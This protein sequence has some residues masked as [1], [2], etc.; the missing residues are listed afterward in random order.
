MASV[1]AS[2]TSQTTQNCLAL[3]TLPTELPLGI[4]LGVPQL[5][6]SPNLS[7]NLCCNFNLALNVSTADLIAL[8]QAAGLNINTL[9]ING[10]ILQ[11]IQALIIAVNTYIDNL[12]LAC[13][14]D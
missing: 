5:S 10:N 7:L 13:P 3:P 8:L 12:P 14:L 9:Q 1:S 11:P 4:S 2:A 6:F